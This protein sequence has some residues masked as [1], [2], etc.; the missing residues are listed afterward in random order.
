M[1]T[2]IITKRIHVTTT[3]TQVEEDG[4]PTKRVWIR[5]DGNPIFVG[6]VGVSPTNGF[7]LSDGQSIE[8]I[9]I[10]SLSELWVVTQSGTGTFSALAEAI[11]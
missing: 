11:S 3:P 9:D 5:G 4:V 10:R 2:R 1:A 7:R 8:G 6:G